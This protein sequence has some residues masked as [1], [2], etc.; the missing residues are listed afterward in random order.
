MPRSKKSAHRFFYDSSMFVSDLA[1]C[2]HPFVSDP[3]KNLIKNRHLRL[4]YE[5]VQQVTYMIL[6]K[7][8]IRTDYLRTREALR[9]AHETSLKMIYIDCHLQR[10][11]NLLQSLAMVKSISIVADGTFYC[12]HFQ[13][14]DLFPLSS[15]VQSIEMISDRDI[16]FHHCWW[17]NQL[18]RFHSRNLRCFSSCSYCV[19]RSKQNGEWKPIQKKKNQ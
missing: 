7:W 1:F 10:S 11:S 15:M 2:S 13:W 9:F 6:R 18:Q 17:W 4:S 3:T 5:I 8:L 19:K 16:D 14:W 12:N